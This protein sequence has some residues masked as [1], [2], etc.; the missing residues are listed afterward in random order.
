MSS[1]LQIIGGIVGGVALIAGIVEISSGPPQ[2]IDT[3]PAPYGLIM[4]SG[5]AVRVMGKGP[6]CTG[7]WVNP[8][9][10]EGKDLVALQN[11]GIVTIDNGRRTVQFE[12]VC[13]KGTYG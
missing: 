3:G 6:F 9:V 4:D 12:E 13:L 1:P 5:F 7:G 11:A 8:M 2:P 10:A